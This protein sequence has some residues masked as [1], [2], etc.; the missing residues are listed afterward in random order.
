MGEGNGNPLQCSCLENPRDRGAWWTSIYGVAQNRTRLMWLSSSSSLSLL[1]GIFPL[2]GIELGSPALQADSLPAELP[3][4]PESH[5]S[6][7]HHIR[8]PPASVHIMFEFT[9]PTTSSSPYLC[10]TWEIL[11]ATENTAMRNTESYWK[12]KGNKINYWYYH[13]EKSWKHQVSKK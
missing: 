10:D 7:H 4:K 13:Q 8:Q 12:A 6:T 5:H 9:G 11:K 2:P 3:R 1:Q